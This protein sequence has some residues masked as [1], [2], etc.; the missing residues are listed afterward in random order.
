VNLE[1]Y[2]GQLAQTLQQPAYSQSDEAIY[3]G[4]ALDAI[5]KE[6][7]ATEQRYIAEL[8]RRGIDPKSGIGL[9]GV[10]KIRNHYAGLRTTEHGNFARKAIDDQRQQRFQV[11]DVMGQQVDAGRQRQQVAQ[12]WARIPYQLQQDSFARNS[13]VAGGN[14]PASYLNSQMQIAD[15][16]AAT[17]RGNQKAQA[18]SIAALMEYLSYMGVV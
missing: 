16:S 8:S 18:D 11:A 3:K 5:Q 4:G 12:Q 1:K 7:D 14:S 13:T 10:L 17:T 6:Q 2:L 9:D 15:G